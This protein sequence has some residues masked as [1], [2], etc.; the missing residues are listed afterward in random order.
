MA[1]ESVKNLTISWMTS[2]IEF[3]SSDDEMERFFFKASDNKQYYIDMRSQN[4]SGELV[5]V[6]LVRDAFLHGKKV[7]IWFE[8]RNGKRWVKAI[9]IWG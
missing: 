8:V 9:N 4:R 2:R 7:G 3:G 1:E 6:T 5:A